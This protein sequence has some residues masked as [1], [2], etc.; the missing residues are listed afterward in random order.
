[1]PKIDFQ[2]MSLG[3]TILRYKTPK[4]IVDEINLIYKQ[5]KKK[6]PHWRDH[7]IGKIHSEHSLFYNG[8]DETLH[9]RHNFLSENIL[10]FFKERVNHYLEWNTIKDYQFK[11]NALWVNEMKAGEYNPAHIHMGDLYTGLSS[12]MFLKIPKSFGKE[13]TREDKPYNGRLNFLGNSAGQFCK[14]DYQPDNIEEG[15][16]L[17]FPYDIR[18][19]VYPFRGK[20]I[21]RTLS[22]NIDVR[23]DQLKSGIA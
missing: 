12:V 13:W 23:Y 8:S 17:L 3:Q 18:H 22:L 19:I 6:L 10:S 11:L 21:R 4:S 16:L 20:G 14:T 1:M 2:F 15:D 7:L 9:K 5:N